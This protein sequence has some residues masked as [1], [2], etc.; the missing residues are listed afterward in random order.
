MNTVP[1][2]NIVKSATA[3]SPANIPYVPSPGFEPRPG[4]A[5]PNVLLMGPPGTGKTWA[6][7]TLVEAGI[8]TFVIITEPNGLANLLTAM[9]VRGLPMAKLH[10]K[11]IPPM[12]ADWAAMEEMTKAVNVQSY[13]ALADLK[14]GIAKPASNTIMKFLKN[15]QNFH[16]DR[17]NNYYGDATLWGYDRALVVD[18]LSGLNMLSVQNT[19]G[20]KPTMHQGEWNIAMNLEETFINKLTSDMKAYFVMLAHVDRNINET[21]G[22]MIITP[23]AIGAKLGPKI[24]K[25][26]SEVI[27][28]V[29]TNDKFTWSTMETGTDVKQSTLKIAKDLPPS[30]KPIVEG[31]NL[32]LKQ[33]AS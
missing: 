31:F 8:E 21:T 25:F 23:A 6:I 22:Q 26:F 3:I 27:L 33:L 13:S 24:G 1:I 15:I 5:A 4:V 30:M 7:T 32:T 14:Q 9:R 2:T 20:L 29:R 11:Y 12:S 10:Y 17:T 28:T 18:S 19:V 16:D